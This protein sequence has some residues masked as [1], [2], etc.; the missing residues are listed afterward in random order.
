M[1]KNYEII[2]SRIHSKGECIVDG[3]FL[4]ETLK[5]IG[6]Q[7]EGR[8]TVGKVHQVNGRN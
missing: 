3:E 6:Y 4:I 7:E 1:N 5:T 8:L 2:L